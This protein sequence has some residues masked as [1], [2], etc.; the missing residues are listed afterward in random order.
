MTTP[1]NCGEI[2]A[3][4]IVGSGATAYPSADFTPTCTGATD[5]LTKTWNDGTTNYYNIPGL[6]DYTGPFG[7]GNGAINVDANLGSANTT[8]IVA[9]TAAGE[10]GYH[11]A[12]RYC[13]RLSYGG[14]TDWYLPNRAEL[15]I[16]WT[17]V[18][19]I[20]G[21]RTE[22]YWYFS[23]TEYNNASSWFQRFSDGYQGGFNKLSPTY[24]RCVRKY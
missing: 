10:G 21:L 19:S 1:G 15:N 5:T 23:S 12:A 18:G 8:N 11:A 7:T 20:P 4:Q 17:N 6:T 3:G 22:G 2:P 9:I 13:D 16:M 14:Y 24:F